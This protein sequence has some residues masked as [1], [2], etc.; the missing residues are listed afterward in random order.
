MVRRL[1]RRALLCCFPL[2]CS[3]CCSSNAGS[4]TC[5]IPTLVKT[6]S[7]EKKLRHLKACTSKLKQ[8]RASGRVDRGVQV[9]L[10]GGS[11][12][13]TTGG[14]ALS[15]MPPPRPRTGAHHQPQAFEYAQP[16]RRIN[17]RRI[18]AFNVEQMVSD[19]GVALLLFVARCCLVCRAH[20]PLLRAPAHPLLRNRRQTVG[21]PSCPRCRTPP[22]ATLRAATAPGTSQR[23]I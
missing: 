3:I 11:L 22:T 19:G 20:A 4:S 2:L 8:Q 9:E 21:P 1:L 14:G 6:S 16:K 17:W 12:L 10:G 7:A 15:G 13:S 23:A 18:H 5:F